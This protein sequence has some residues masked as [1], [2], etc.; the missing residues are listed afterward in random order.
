[1]SFDNVE[2]HQN[3]TGTPKSIPGL[4][5]VTYKYGSVKKDTD[6]NTYVCLTYPGDGGIPRMG[7]TNLA[8]NGTDVVIEADLMIENGF[9]LTKPF[10][11]IKL[12][13]ATDATNAYT[14]ES[15]GKSK[16]LSWKL[17][18]LYGDGENGM[19]LGDSVNENNPVSIATVKAGEW[20]RVKI[21]CNM[22]EYVE[23]NDVK[24]YGTKDIYV[25]GQ[26]VL[27]DSPLGAYPLPDIDHPDTPKWVDDDCSTLDV[28][29]IVFSE[30]SARAA[31]SSLCIDNYQF[32]TDLS[33][34]GFDRSISS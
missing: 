6:G 7:I 4:L 29:S 31:G 12:Y 1:M 10:S 34:V 33:S 17:L 19:F 18:H 28:T 9:D 20:F 25:N 11:L 27:K 2:E 8:Y 21:V 23:Y 26:L 5:G 24:Y 30:W 22:K 14:L 13:G 3:N 15:Y 16:S 32:R